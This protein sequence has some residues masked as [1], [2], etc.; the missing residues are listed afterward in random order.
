M[1]DKVS[2]L[3]NR[4]QRRVK[5]CSDENL[6][7]KRNSGLNEQS[8][9]HLATPGID[10]ESINL[11][12]VF[13]GKKM[14]CPY[15]IVGVAG[16]DGSKINHKLA[17]A[18]QE[19]GMALALGPGRL[20]LLDE[21]SVE[22]YN[23]RKIAPSIPLFAQIELSWENEICTLEQA[24][25]LVTMLDADGLIL[26]LDFFEAA[27]CGQ[28]VSAKEALEQVSKIVTGLRSE[29]IPV[30]VSEV[31]F[32][33]DLS[34][35]RKLI[36]ARVDAFMV[37]GA[38]GVSPAKCS[39]QVVSDPSFARVG[40]VFGDWGMGIVE[41]IHQIRAVSEQVP[42]VAGGGVRHGLDAAK[43]L[44]LGC[45]IVSLHSPFVAAAA[46]GQDAVNVICQQIIKELHLTMFGLGVLNIDEL[47]NG[48]RLRE[49]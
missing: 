16:G 20:A 33:M 45:D 18:A 13:L 23:V 14:M 35:S 10:F 36:E 2:M 41:S 8:F 39:S 29:H 32:G 34:T 22:D 46:Q 43:L 21:D 24:K 26:R 4:A 31:G 6:L 27:L 30:L 19:Y 37:I 12:T 1:D 25:H 48:K 7:L 42:L 15:L 38:G 3:K 49:M 40:D 17:E 9:V 5:A 47:R 28:H 11:N 44:A